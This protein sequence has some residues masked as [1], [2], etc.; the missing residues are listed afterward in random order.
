M[1]D[2][3]DEGH[4]ILAELAALKLRVTAIVHTHAHIDHVGA[5]AQLGRVTQ[6]PCYLHAEDRFLHE[7]LPIQAQLL[8][9]PAPQSGV[10]DRALVHDQTVRFGNYELGIIHTPGHTPGSVCFD[11]PGEDLCFSGDTLFNGGIGRTDLW[12][13]DSQAIM[14]SIQKRLY[15]LHGAVQVIPGHGPPTSI[16]RER[17]QNPYVRA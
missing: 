5:T 14:N 2:P 7:M 12:G 9:L 10:M 11:L 4:R 6:A 1:V 3:G 13:G 8:G 17:S 15:S 16:D